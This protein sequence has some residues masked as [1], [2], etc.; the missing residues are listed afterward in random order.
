MRP[1][2]SLEF[3]RV[4]CERKLDIIIS[5]SSILKDINSMKTDDRLGF[6]APIKYSKSNN[7]Y[8]YSDPEFSIKKLSLQEPEIEALKMA[9]DVLSIFSGTRVSDNFNLAIEKVL[10]SVHEQFPES[11]RKIIQTDT[12]PNHKGFE[13]FELLLNSATTKTPVNFIHYSY[14]NRIFKSVIVH[15]YLLKEFQNNWYLVGYSE[16]HNEQRTFGLDRIYEPILLKHSF[17]APD[18]E[19]I[20]Q[21]FENI[22]GVYP[23]ENQALQKIEFV[24]NPFLSD[25]LN[26]HPIHQSQKRIRQTSYGHAI[27]TLDLIP[28]RE[29]INFFLSYSHQLIVREPIWIQEE[30]KVHHQKAIRYEK[31]YKS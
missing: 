16:T 29:L 4:E 2:P 10:A 12:T 22:Y 11:K 24:V 26:A 30:I 3:L 28:T 23:L 1:Y 13:N 5:E 31:N 19:K 6:D 27:F 17:I 15:P 21:Y 18:I 14:K 8:Y 25:Y 9:V 20:N 7:G